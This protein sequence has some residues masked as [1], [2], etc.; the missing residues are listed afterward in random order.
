MYIGILIFLSLIVSFFLFYLYNE[1]ESK[2]EIMG[3]SILLVLAGFVFYYIDQSGT[4]GFFIG[5]GLV[6]V[7]LF[8]GSMCFLHK[9]N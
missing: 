8:F 6:L 3:F 7:G 9:S 5:L 1:E 4:F 2:T